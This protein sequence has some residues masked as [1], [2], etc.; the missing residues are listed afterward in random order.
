MSLRVGKRGDFGGEIAVSAARKRE[1]HVFLGKYSNSTEIVASAQAILGNLVELGALFKL[2]VLAA[3]SNG[4][5]I[6]HLNHLIA[7]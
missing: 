7:Q 6:S 3:E 2:P 4:P 1:V 5:L